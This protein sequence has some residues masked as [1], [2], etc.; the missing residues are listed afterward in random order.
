MLRS[1][2]RPGRGNTYCNFSPKNFLREA[3]KLL[4]GVQE[5]IKQPQIVAEEAVCRWKIRRE[6]GRE[7]N[8]DWIP[9]NCPLLYLEEPE[10]FGRC[11]SRKRLPLHIRMLNPNHTITTVPPLLFNLRALDSLCLEYSREDS[12]KYWKTAETDQKQPRRQKSHAKKVPQ[13]EKLFPSVRGKPLPT[14]DPGW[15]VSTPRPDQNL[16][17][18]SAYHA[19]RLLRRNRNEKD[20]TP[21]DQEIFHIHKVEIQPRSP[22]PPPDPRSR[23]RELT[24]N[25]LWGTK[26]DK[27][28]RREKQ[29][30][31][32]ACSDG[33]NETPLMGGRHKKRTF[34]CYAVRRVGGDSP[35]A[36]FPLHRG[37]SFV[38]SDGRRY[39]LSREAAR[40]SASLYDIV[41]HGEEYFNCGSKLAKEILTPPAT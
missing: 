41:T 15:V 23:S 31:Q 25:D 34:F 6:G 4:E 3:T 26:L 16:V 30:Q 39:F 19:V 36:T 2:P 27:V 13:P 24:Q 8:G 29:K 40:E 37:I 9:P 38:H 12:G 28:S 7:S 17:L 35:P 18:E 5:R 21:A 11:K 20:K 22:L 33:R 1:L 10:S 14:P 32:Q